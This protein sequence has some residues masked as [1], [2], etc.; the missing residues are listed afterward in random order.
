MNLAV[1][2]GGF[3]TCVGPC[4]VMRK[5]KKMAALEILEWAGWDVVAVIKILTSPVKGSWDD[6]SL[7]ALGE[8][9]MGR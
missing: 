2:V 9:V 7:Y 6:T 5:G 8:D 3:L 4:A 1:L